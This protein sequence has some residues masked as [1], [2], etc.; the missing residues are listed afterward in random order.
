[1]VPGTHK[2]SRHQAEH[3]MTCSR[4]F[5]H[6]CKGI[7]MATFK[8]EEIRALEEGGNGASCLQLLCCLQ[9]LWTAVCRE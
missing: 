3:V 8:P 7:S 5:S 6:R 4:Q 2:S 9:L 1:M